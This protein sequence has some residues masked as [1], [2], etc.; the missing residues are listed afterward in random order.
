MN[1]ISYSFKKMLRL[2]PKQDCLSFS[3]LVQIEWIKASDVDKKHNL[4]EKN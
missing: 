4:L 2:P 3:S 1:S